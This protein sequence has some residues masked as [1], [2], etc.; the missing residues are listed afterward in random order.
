MRSYIRCYE[1]RNSWLRIPN[2]HHVHMERLESVDGV[3]H[4]LA[5]DAGGQLHF[6]VDDIGAEAL[7]R[8]LERHA[9]ARGGFGEQVRHRNTRQCV[10][11]R[12]RRSQWAN[13][14]LRLVQ[15]ALDL[16]A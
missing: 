13:E 14:G 16:G 4:A 10:A 3:Q 7:G 2:Y 12:W 15:Q 11:A 5:L 1:R 6:Q 9:G 8:E